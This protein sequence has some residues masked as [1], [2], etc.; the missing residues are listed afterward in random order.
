MPEHLLVPT[1]PRSQP[2]LMAG[3]WPG[4]KQGCWWPEESKLNVVEMGLAMS[5]LQ[6]PEE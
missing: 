3:S 6:F 1:W 2:R 4:W 5:G